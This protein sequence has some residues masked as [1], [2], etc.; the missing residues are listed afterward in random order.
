MTKFC[1]YLVFI[2][3]VNRKFEFLAYNKAIKREFAGHITIMLLSTMH[4]ILTIN[5]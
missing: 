1:T 2:L 3:S 5:G 4:I